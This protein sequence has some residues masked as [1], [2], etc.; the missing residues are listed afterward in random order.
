MITP[1]QKG[2]TT[3]TG[4]RVSVYPQAGRIVSLSVYA[5]S[6]VSIAYKRRYVWVGMH[7]D[8]TSTKFTSSTYMQQPHSHTHSWFW[9]RSTHEYA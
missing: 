7:R 8:F 1:R 6:D 9:Q 2:R 3:E 4:N 5:S